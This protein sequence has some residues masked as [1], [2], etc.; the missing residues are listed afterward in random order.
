MGGK[1]RVADLS[2]IFAKVLSKTDTVAKV[3]D[4]SALIDAAGPGRKVYQVTVSRTH[5]LPLTAILLIITAVYIARIDTSLVGT[6]CGTRV[7]YPVRWWSVCL[8]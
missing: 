3:T 1:K 2:E 7:W 4:G 8:L 5:D 6:W